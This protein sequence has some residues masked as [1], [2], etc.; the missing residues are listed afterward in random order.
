MECRAQLGP[1]LPLQQVTNL[2]DGDRDLDQRLLQSGQALI[3]RSK[4]G[5]G[6]GKVE[7]G[8]VHRFPG[9][10]EDTSGRYEVGQPQPGTEQPDTRRNATRQQGGRT[11]AGSQQGRRGCGGTTCHAGQCCGRRSRRQQMR[12][13]LP[14]LRSS[15][16]MA[17]HAAVQGV[18]SGD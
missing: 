2:L 6:D 16:G 12:D 4:P 7:F 1:L 9:R 15:G 11:Q 17:D 13:N 14:A 18:G 10:C 8:Q 3:Q 5:T